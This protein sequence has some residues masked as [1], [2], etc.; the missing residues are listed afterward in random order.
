MIVLRDGQRAAYLADQRA[1]R[2]AGSRATIELLNL[3]LT[4]ADSVIASRARA[5]G[6]Q[7]EWR[8]AATES[9]SAAECS[10]CAPPPRR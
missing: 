10:T 9:S 5:K 4:S 2:L 3:L 8:A 1:V 6:T 7:V